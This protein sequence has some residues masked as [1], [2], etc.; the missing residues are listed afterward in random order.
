RAG[1]PEGGPARAS[2]SR[3]ACVAPSNAPP[4]T[5]GCRLPKPSPRTREARGPAAP[6]EASDYRLHRSL[7]E[8]GGGGDPPGRVPEERRPLGG[9]ALHEALMRLFQP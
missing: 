9:E 7:E 3:H 1:L 8:G 4:R 2:G 5:G 6:E